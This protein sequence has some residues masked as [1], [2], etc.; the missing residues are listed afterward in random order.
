MRHRGEVGDNGHPVHVLAQRQRQPALGLGKLRGHE[1]LAEVDGGPLVVGHLHRDRAAAR[2]R[3][4][5]PHARGLERQREIVGEVDDLCDLHPG[6]RLELV[7][8]DDRP[9]AHLHDAPVD[10]EV[11]Q[12]ASQDLGVVLQL[13]ARRLELG[14]RR[15]LQQADGRQLEGRR[16]AGAEVERLLPREPLVHQRALRSGGLHDGRQRQLDRVGG[17][18]RDERRRR[19]RPRCR[20]RREGAALAQGHQPRGHQPRERRVRRLRDEQRAD[21]D[22]REQQQPGARVAHRRVQHDGGR[23]PGEAAGLQ[24]AAVREARTRERVRPLLQQ[25]GRREQQQEQADDRHPAA[26]RERAHECGDAP[27][28]GGE[29]E[30][31]R[32]IAECPDA[33]PRDPDADGT[34]DG[35]LIARWQRGVEHRERDEEKHGRGH[36]RDALHLAHPPAR[37]SLAARAAARLTRR[38]G[39]LRLRL[40][41]RGQSRRHQTS[42]M[43]GS[44]IGLRCTRWLTSWRTAV[45]TRAPIASRSHGSAGSRA[46][47]AART[48]DFMSSSSASF[49]FT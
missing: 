48:A 11:G 17:R 39:R 41:L 23:P 44:T 8:G 2:D 14:A 15:R 38:L 33:G 47:S 45:R 37:R 12:L 34:D 24:H 22:R 1:D 10:L 35:G 21:R 40:Q 31:E 25:A 27:E 7:R 4:D 32:G 49:S 42:R 20:Q 28:G 18:V 9:R 3:S 46:V 26:R 36:R 43:M 6:R 30:E 16:A 29:R 19:E 5:D 13:L